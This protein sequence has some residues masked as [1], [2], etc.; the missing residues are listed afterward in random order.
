MSRLLGHLVLIEKSAE[1]SIAK[2]LFLH[3]YSLIE[4]RTL[5]FPTPK[6]PSSEVGAMIPFYDMCNHSEEVNQHN[7][8]SLFHFDS[9]TS[10]YVIRAY[11]NFN[12]G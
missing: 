1:Q 6:D 10:S 7:I 11:R 8:Y 3:C 2:E 9:Q 5:Y 4:S 12:K